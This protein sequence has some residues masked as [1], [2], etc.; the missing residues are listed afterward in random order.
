MNDPALPPIDF[1]QLGP[2]AGP[3]AV[4][5]WH[6]LGPVVYTVWLVIVSG[7]QGPQ[8]AAG[9][10]ALFAG[11]AQGLADLLAMVLR[12]VLVVVTTIIAVILMG[13]IAALMIAALA[14]DQR[15]RRNR[16][17]ASS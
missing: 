3:F 17:R 15:P 5:F 9:M 4:A 7:T 11:A 6:I 16:G 8:I 1:T 2:V 14:S 13:A 12:I 10:T